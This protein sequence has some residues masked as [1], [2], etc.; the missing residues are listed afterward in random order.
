MAAADVKQDDSKVDALTEKQ[1][2]HKIKLKEASDELMKKLITEF[3]EPKNK[4]K[5]ES[6]FSRPN[7]L[8]K[9]AKKKNRKVDAKG[10]GKDK[11]KGD[12]KDDK[13]DNDVDDEKFA[14]KAANGGKINLLDLGGGGTACTKPDGTYEFPDKD[15]I[16]E[17]DIIAKMEEAYTLGKK[18]RVVG[19]NHSPEFTIF[20]E[21]TIDP[22][23]GTTILV[24]LDKYHGILIGDEDEQTHDVLVTVD[25]GILLGSRTSRLPTNLLSF[26]WDKGIVKQLHDTGLSLTDLGGVVHQAAGG[27]LSMGCAGGTIEHDFNETIS[28]IRLLVFDEN[29]AGKV[30]AKDYPRPDSEDGTINDEFWGVVNSM[31]LCGVISKITFKLNTVTNATYPVV[32]TQ[33]A[34]IKDDWA[35]TGDGNVASARDSVGIVDFTAKNNSDENSLYKKLK[36]M[37]KLQ[38]EYMRFFWAPQSTDNWIQ[39]WK[40]HRATEDDAKDETYVEK[41]MIVTLLVFFFSR[42]F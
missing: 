5:L 22:N 2:A 3:G 12:A 13:K 29:N 31:G 25:A 38:T 37:S 18:F 14:A 28:N 10:K 8:I 33:V 35:K 36:D 15:T 17:S 30:I 40:A 42:F 1:K 9:L 4:L 27:F 16:Q 6:I 7:E 32:G 20:D 34:L 26:G 39:M 41:G 23:D 21:G 24:N 19:S 11:D